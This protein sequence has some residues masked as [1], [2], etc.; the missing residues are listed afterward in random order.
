LELGAPER[1]Q[2]MLHC[3]LTLPLDCVLR[4]GS[5]S[6]FCATMEHKGIPYRIV[7][8]ANPTGFTWIVELEANRTKTG[9]SRSRGNAIFSAARAIEQCL[10]ARGYPVEE[11]L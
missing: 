3:T 10:E 7:Q 2:V 4:T 5:W 11:A 9:F 8:T 6:A 1:A